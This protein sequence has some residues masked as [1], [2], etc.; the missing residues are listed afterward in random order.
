[1][2]FGMEALWHGSTS[3]CHERDMAQSVRC[4]Y[5]QHL[6]CTRLAKPVLK[7]L[8]DKVQNDIRYSCRKTNFILS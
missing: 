7:F 8:Q 5:N 4:N 3:V 6:H 1:M 2:R